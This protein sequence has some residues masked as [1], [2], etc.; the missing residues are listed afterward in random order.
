MKPMTSSS[1]SVARELP[2]FSVRNQR[3]MLDADLA[4]IYGVSTKRFNE[5]FKRNRKK[6]PSDF[7]FQLSALETKNLRSQLATS[8]SKTV[9]EHED[10][11]NRSQSVTSS[12]QSAFNQ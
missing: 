12:S 10:R 2:L 1:A 4:R 6:F 11:G 5:A 7:V 9:D 3:V 8:S